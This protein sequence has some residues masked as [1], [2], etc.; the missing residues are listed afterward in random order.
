MAVLTTPGIFSICPPDI[1]LYL[2]RWFTIGSNAHMLKSIFI[3]SMIGLQPV[4]AAPIPN[5][6]IA[7]SARGESMILSGPYL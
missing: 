2:A 4:M 7:F 5:P 1:Y 3:I 6:T